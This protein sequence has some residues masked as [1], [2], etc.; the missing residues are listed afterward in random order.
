MTGG[1]L[2]GAM[3]VIA[4]R[5]LPGQV[6]TRLTP[7]F[8]PDQACELASAALADTLAV[9]NEVAA[10]EHILCFS[11]PPGEW[12]PAGWRGVV[13]RPGGLDVRLAAAF[14][15]AGA[16]P[17]VLVGMDTPQGRC[18]QIASFD[19]SWYDACLGM[20]A[21]GGY[22]AIGFRDPRVARTVIT[23]VRMSSEHT[24]EDQLERM[25]GAGLRVQ[26]LD[27]L[28][29]VDTAFSARAVATAAPATRFAAR[30]GQTTV[31]A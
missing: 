28:V 15:A 6:K 31:V 27:V 8:T 17:A 10:H 26:L 9:A 13:Q 1:P 25:L 24:G 12:L 11:E 19:P 14:D 4:K 23:G 21:D 3:I 18:E 5:P 22:W 29:D 20:A 16:G 30:F 7:P 2:L